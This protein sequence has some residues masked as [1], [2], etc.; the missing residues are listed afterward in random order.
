MQRISNR[1][2]IFAKRCLTAHQRFQVPK[3][4]LF[5]PDY[6]YRARMTGSVLSGMKD[7]VEGCEKIFK[8]KTKQF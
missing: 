6:H 8:F 4:L 2:F 1:N 7:F 3:K 5:H